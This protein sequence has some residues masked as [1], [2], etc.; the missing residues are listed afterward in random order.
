MDEFDGC[1]DGCILYGSHAFG[2]QDIEGQ[3]VQ[4]Q[5]ELMDQGAGLH[6]SQKGTVIVVN[7]QQSQEMVQDAAELVGVIDAVV[8]ADEIIKQLGM[9]ASDGHIN[10][11][12]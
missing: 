10:E 4:I 1:I 12:S 8:L 5:Q 2:F 11:K 3:L 7:G 9:G 6:L